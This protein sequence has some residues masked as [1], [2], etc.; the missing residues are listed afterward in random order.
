MANIHCKQCHMEFPEEGTDRC[1]GCG[2][3]VDAAGPP[4]R[5]PGAEPREGLTTEPAPE[6]ASETDS[7]PP[8][9]EQPATET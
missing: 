9:D 4:A 8:G 5:P 6:P 1:P 2:R 7:E 3:P